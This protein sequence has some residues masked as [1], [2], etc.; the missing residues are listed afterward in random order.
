MDTV[1]GLANFRDLGGLP[2]D[3]G[4]VTRSG[5]LYR[6]D[7]PLP[8]DPCPS[9][10]PWPPVTVI[11]LRS[12]D[13]PI[14]PHPLRTPT[15]LLARFPLLGEARPKTLR[16]LLA[17]GNVRLEAIYRELVARVGEV[18]VAVLELLVAADGPTL[19]HCAAGKDRTGV[20]IATLLR[21]AGVTRDAIVADY[22]RTAAAMTSVR[23]RMSSSDEEVAALMAQFPEA[24][25]APAEAISGVLEQVDG[26]LGGSGGWLTSRGVPIELINAWRD[27]LVDRTT[28]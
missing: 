8:G 12:H 9:G 1:P 18:A 2:T 23:R 20:L 19:I 15:T 22:V 17:G 4:A 24:T 3:D 7:A 6:S 25:L 13:E 21:A 10:P 16:E 5:V 11:D 26:S 28:T 27:K 14:E